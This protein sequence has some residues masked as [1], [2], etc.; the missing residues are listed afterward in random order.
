[1]Q[2]SFARPSFYMSLCMLQHVTLLIRYV[3]KLLSV[4]D[5]L[6]A[7]FKAL[8]ITDMYFHYHA[9]SSFSGRGFQTPE[10]TERIF[11]SH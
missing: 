9:F 11:S 8:N 2:A 10:R 4:L 5:I 1:M 6:H 7:C 3:L